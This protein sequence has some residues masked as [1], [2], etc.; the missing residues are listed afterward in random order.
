MKN[1]KSPPSFKPGGG[2]LEICILKFA[3]TSNMAHVNP[4]LTGQ[5]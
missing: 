4:K 1:A 2:Q 5:K 3:L